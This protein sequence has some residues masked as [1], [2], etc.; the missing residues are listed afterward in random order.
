M[1]RPC[2]RVLP[3]AILLAVAAS[4]AACAG[5]QK[6]ED[7]HETVQRYLQYAGT[8]I[9]RFSKM[10]GFTGWRALDRDQLVVWTGVNTAYLL[11]IATPCEDPRFENTI[12]VDSQGSAVHVYDSVIV[13]DDRCPI[14][15]IREVDYR[16]MKKDA[17]E[18]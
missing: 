18:Q 4:L 1:K 15:E 2:P 11:R 5:I 10:T 16:Q 3:L 14:L 6:R 8:P 12:A 17:R 7:D 13:R 9:E